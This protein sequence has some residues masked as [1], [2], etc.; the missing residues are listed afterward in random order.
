MKASEEN[1]K[2]VIPAIISK[3]GGALLGLQGG[4]LTGSSLGRD[5]LRGSTD[6][7]HSRIS[8]GSQ[9]QPSD[10]EQQ[11]FVTS[12]LD[13]CPHPLTATRDKLMLYINKIDDYYDIT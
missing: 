11:T 10:R 2:V 13:E 3:E 12:L 5:N 9:R 6:R 7:L 4:P 8:L 1:S